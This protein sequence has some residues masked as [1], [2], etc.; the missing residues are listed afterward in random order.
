M[1]VYN[2]IVRP[3]CDVRR[4][5][6]QI[7]VGVIA[8]WALIEIAQQLD[9]VQTQAEGPRGHR[10]PERVHAGGEVRG[11]LPDASK[12]V[13][14]PWRLTAPMMATSTNRVLPAPS[15][16]AAAITR[17]GSAAIRSAT[18]VS[19]LNAGTILPTTSHRPSLVTVSS[20]MSVERTAVCTENLCV[21][22]VVVTS[23][24]DGV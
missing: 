7:H 15:M 23:A 8:Q 3:P 13:R 22:V 14:M 2:K 18:M 19:S 5:R 20:T 11:H 9:Q 17:G 10:N 24:K 4:M 16:L 12:G 6:P 1:F 21:G